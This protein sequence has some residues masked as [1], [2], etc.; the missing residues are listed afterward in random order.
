MSQLDNKVKSIFD[1]VII[2]VALFSALVLGNTALATGGILLVML[3]D[4][5]PKGD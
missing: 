5:L 2:G 1:F 3:A 4:R